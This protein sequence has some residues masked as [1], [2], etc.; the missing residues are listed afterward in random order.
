MNPLDMNSPSN[1]VKI[2]D[3][4]EPQQNTT[5]SAHS[6]I[7]EVDFDF[8][9]YQVVRGEFFSHLHEPAF[10]FS[11]DKVYVN[12]SCL[13]KLP[14]FDYVQILVNPEEKKLAVR[15]CLEDERDSFRWCSS[16][17]KRTPKQITCRMF[18]AKVMSLMGWNPSYRYK[19]LGKLIHSNSEFLF[20]F[21][22]NSPEIYQ[23]QLKD[24]GKA[25]T[26]RT[27][28]FP[29]EWKNQFGMSYKEHQN[30]LKVGVF[31]EYTVFGLEKDPKNTSKQSKEEVTA[32]EQQSFTNTETMSPTGPQ[33]MPYPNSQINAPSAGGPRIYPTTGQP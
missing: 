13:K 27:P 19:L 11:S 20:L 16:T 26:S 28:T 6:E 15:P 18:F 21:D 25:R 2:S 9:G 10:S 5:V 22:L 32:Y 8:D 29:E 30:S 4:F 17:K 7:E 12:S 23:R 31:D 1:A 24:N 14:E 33:K 3:S